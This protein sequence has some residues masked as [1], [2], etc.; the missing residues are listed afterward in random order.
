MNIH[1]SLRNIFINFCVSNVID[2]TH[3]LNGWWWNMFILFIYIYIYIYI[4]IAI[5]L[6][7]AR[8]QF[9]TDAHGCCNCHMCITDAL[10]VVQYSLGHVTAI[11]FLTQ[12]QWHEANVLDN[13]QLAVLPQSGGSEIDPRWAHDILSVPLWVYMRFPVPE[14]YN[15]DQ[16][17]HRNSS[18][19]FAYRL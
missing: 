12:F 14:H 8:A 10:P 13:W 4:C 18:S 7:R 11:E 6:S 1:N 5:T 2:H 3:S 19:Y 17:I 9:K 15:C 16:L